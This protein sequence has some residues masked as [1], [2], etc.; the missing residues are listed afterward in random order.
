MKE[1][2]RIVRELD[3]EIDRME[4]EINYLTEHYEIKSRREIVHD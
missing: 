1:K 3:V 4:A 2:E